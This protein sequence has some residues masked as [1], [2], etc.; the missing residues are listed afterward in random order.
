[1]K[2]ELQALDQPTR[3]LTAAIAWLAICAY[4]GSATRPPTFV[5]GPSVLAGSSTER[6]WLNDCRVADSVSTYGWPNASVFK[7]A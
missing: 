4:P 2:E 1:M 6:R 7:N 5:K 3:P